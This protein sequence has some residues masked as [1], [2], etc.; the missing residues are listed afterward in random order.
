MIRAFA[1][2]AGRFPQARLAV[3]GTGPLEAMAREEA[4]RLGI[5]DRVDWLGLQ[6]GPSVM[7]LFDVFLLPSRYE[8]LPYVLIEAMAKGLPLVTTRIGGAGTLVEEG[9]NGHTAPHS[10]PDLLAEALAKV[11]GD[12]ALRADMGRASLRKSAYFTADR[13][14][15]DNIRVYGSLIA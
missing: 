12:A 7:A 3:V 2:V 6:D 1:L 13:M 15:A 8:G 5:A 4:A 10:R 9:V 14:V 11:L